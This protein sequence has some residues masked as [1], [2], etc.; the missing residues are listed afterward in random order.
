MAEIPSDAHADCGQW[1]PNSMLLDQNECLTT[2]TSELIGEAS[3]GKPATFG[4]GF[5]V[6][7]R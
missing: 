1:Q 6:M 3:P 4:I 7:S 5:E 2:E